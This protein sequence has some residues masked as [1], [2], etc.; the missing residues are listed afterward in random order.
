MEN[1]A[2]YIRI[3]SATQKLER[4]LAKQHTGEQLYIDVISG[5]VP[6]AERLKASDLKRDIEDGLIKYVSVSSIDRVGRNLQDI[7]NTLAFFE[8]HNVTL[9]V[10]NLGLESFVNGKKNPTFELIISVMGSVAV[11]ERE[12]MLERQK[13]GIAVAVAKGIYKGRLK[14]SKETTAVFLQR[15]KGTVKLLKQGLSLRKTAQLQGCSLGLIQKV[16]KAMKQQ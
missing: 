13:E 2:R 10:D 1:K 11:M 7:I 4:Q 15:N 5:V 9:R 16:S 6:F 3:S 12:T 8:A 14:G